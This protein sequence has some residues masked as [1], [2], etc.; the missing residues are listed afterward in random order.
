MD[1][2]TVNQVSTFLFPPLSPAPFQHSPHPT[3]S[4]VMK[5]VFF[6]LYLTGRGNIPV[7]N[8]LSWLGPFVHQLVRSSAG[9]IGVHLWY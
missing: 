4:V 1:R 8:E 6:S 9:L 3:P 7:P 2:E 5:M